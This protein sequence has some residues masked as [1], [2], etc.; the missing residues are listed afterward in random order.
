MPAPPPVADLV[1]A[2]LIDQVP[3]DVPALLD[4]LPGADLYLQDEVQVAFHPT[5]TRVWCRQGRR[6]QRLVE[7][8]GANDK[9][10]GF[11]IVD[12]CTGWFEGRLAGGRTADVFCAQVRAAVARSQARARLAIVVADNLR[13]HTAA[14]SK[15]VRE[16]L[17][18]LEGQ[19]VLVYTP[20]YDPDANRIEWL[21]RWTRREVTHNH[22][23]Q[24]FD[25]LQADL[26]Y[27]FERLVA[28]P[29]AVLRQLGSPYADGPLL[30]PPSV[31]H[32]RITRA[33]DQPLLLAA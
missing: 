12:W 26:R 17:E 23:R 20:P 4:R 6:G 19:L 11:G 14:G 33:V 15:L 28:Q 30:H 29:H 5:L 32:T 7:A 10:Y 21:W 16:M 22:Q 8:P 13:T 31:V 18:E 1:D 27:H 9:V 25:D 2:D 24:V 3:P